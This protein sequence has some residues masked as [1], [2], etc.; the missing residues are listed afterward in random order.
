MLNPSKL[1]MSHL[2]L[3]RRIC[4]SSKQLEDILQDCL[5]ESPGWRPPLTDG[6]AHNRSYLG[7]TAHWLD[8]KTACCPGL[9]SD[10]STADF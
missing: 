6:S 1:F 7:M 5:R 3:G 10:Q 2:T 9:L 4:A 8:L